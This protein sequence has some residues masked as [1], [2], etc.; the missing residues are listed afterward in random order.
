VDITGGLVS[1]WLLWRHELLVGLLVAFLPS[2]IVTLLMVRWM[3]FT[4]QRDSTFGKYIAYHM[5]RLAQTIRMGGQVGMWVG[6]WFH[7]PWAIIVGAV[8]IFFGWTYSLS[9]WRTRTGARA[10]PSA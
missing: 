4:R 10:R 9:S 5:T 6:A 7:F 3:D 1:T 8:V 2:V